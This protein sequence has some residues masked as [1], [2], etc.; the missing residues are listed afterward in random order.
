MVSRAASI[1]AKALLVGTGPRTTRITDLPWLKCGSAFLRARP[2][3]S[4]QT[5]RMSG[6][7][8]RR[9]AAR[10]VVFDREDR[11]L[12]LHAIDPADPAKPAWWE[13]PGGGINPGEESAETA[14]RELY[15]ETGITDVEI[16]PCVW[17]RDTEFDF[18]GFHFIQNER[19]HVAWCD[20]GEIHPQALELLEMEAFQGSRWWTMQDLALSD[21]QTWPSQ[22][23]VLL[24]P[25]M[26]GEIPTSPIEIAD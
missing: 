20:G 16:G 18:G 9:R 3:Q 8:W 23:R 11:V 5:S 7:V 22:L 17:L 21:A 19:I 24:P 12:L 13:I 10:V 2:L 25:L 15:E 14:R 4:D 26:A 1:H 6:P